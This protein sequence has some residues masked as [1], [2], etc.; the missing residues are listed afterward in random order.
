MKKLI[1]LCGCLLT[2]ISTNAAINDAPEIII[3]MTGPTTKKSALPEIAIWNKNATQLTRLFTGKDRTYALY[4]IENV[5][6][7]DGILHAKNGTKYAFV[8]YRDPSGTFRKFLFKNNEP[9]T[10]VA[11]AA[12]AQD[13]LSINQKHNVNIGLKKDQFLLY[14]PQAVK[15]TDL[16]INAQE[17][18]RINWTGDKKQ[19]TP[20]YVVFENDELTDQILGKE[21]WDKYVQQQTNAENERLHKE[22]EE[23]TP[24]PTPA[25][26]K[27]A[28]KP[29]KALVSG[30]T[31]QDRMYMPHLIQKESAK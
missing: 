3:E 2:A 26:K 30:G 11:C 5:S 4:T 12:T 21:A 25:A 6:N 18:F 24:T 29:Y 23:K 19:T 1:I 14:Y 22:L 28:S 13:V 17:V 9:Q 8:E 31:V 15:I 10:F 16:K 7:Y 20:L 27:P